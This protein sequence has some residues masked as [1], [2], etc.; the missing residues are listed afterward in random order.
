[1][2]FE[3]SNTIY[4]KKE[5]EENEMI[6]F[7][8][9]MKST[10]LCLIFLF[11]YYR[12]EQLL[13]GWSPTTDESLKYDC[14]QRALVQI[15]GAKIDN[16]IY[17]QASDLVCKTQIVNGLNI[18]CEFH[19]RG[20]KWQCSY[21]KSFIQTLETQLEQCKQVQDEEKDDEQVAQ[22]LETSNE[23]DKDDQEIV[24]NELVAEF[25]HSFSMRLYVEERNW[26]HLLAKV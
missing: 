23:G 24:G 25:F 22:D 17:S 10:I 16:D 15:N 26:L 3:L 7:S 6:F 5:E 2:Y 12:C 18:K 20:Q 9:K 13:G 4:I 1:M 14:L 21:Y 11:N 19:F 8:D